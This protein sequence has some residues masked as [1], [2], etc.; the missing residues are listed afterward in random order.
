MKK[1]ILL[2]ILSILAPYAV[3]QVDDLKELLLSKAEGLRGKSLTRWRVFGIPI[4][5]RIKGS[6]IDKFQAKVREIDALTVASYLERLAAA[7]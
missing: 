3:D 5:V 2:L 7:L 1:Q 4:R 6:D